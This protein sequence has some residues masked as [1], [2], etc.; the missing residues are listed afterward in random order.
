MRNEEFLVLTYCFAGLISLGLALAVYLYL[1][2]P[3]EQIVDALHQKN[4]AAICKKAFTI[5]IFLLALSGFLYVNYSCGGPDYTKIVSSRSEIIS[6]N[7]GHIV[8]A[9]S[10]MVIVLFVW[11]VAVLLFLVALLRRRLGVKSR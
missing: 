9:A 7:E 1:R 4:W 5:S 8:Q 6:V 3:F 11:A 10:S 2:R